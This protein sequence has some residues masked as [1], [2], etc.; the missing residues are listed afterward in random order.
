M[1]LRN[2]VSERIPN[3]IEMQ[4]AKLAFRSNYPMARGPNIERPDVDV[5]IDIDIDVDIH[6]DVVTVDVDV[7][8]P[9]DVDKVAKKEAATRKTSILP[10][11]VPSTEFSTSLKLCVCKIS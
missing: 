4:M 10:A 6:V 8:I 5:D 1:D 3:K 9:V 2:V 7:D 11:I